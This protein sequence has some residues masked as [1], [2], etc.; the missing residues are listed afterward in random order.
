MSCKHKQLNVVSW[1]VRGLNDDD[2]CVLLHDSCRDANPHLV[3]LQETK[4]TDP[5]LNIIHSFLPYRL[6]DHHLVNACDTRGSV[7]TAWNSSTLALT[8]V[9]CRTYS[10]TTAFESTTSD[11]NSR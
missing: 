1:N 5:S 3:C 2:K 4:L 7:L 11:H 10:L 8:S 9:D 6:N